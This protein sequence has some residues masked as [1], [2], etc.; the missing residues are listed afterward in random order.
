MAKQIIWSSEQQ[1]IFNYFK[2]GSG[3][4]CIEALAGCGKTSTIEEGI[5]HA[6]EKR[7]LYAVFGKRNQL[8]AMEKIIDPR[9][10]IATIHSVGF[11]YLKTVWP[12]CH[13]RFSWQVECDR[14]KTACPEF[15]EEFNFIVQKLISLLKNLYINPTLENAKD[16]AGIRGLEIYGEQKKWNDEI[17]RIAI[18]AIELSKRPDKSNR[19]SFDDMVYLPA[20]LQL[21]KPQYDMVVLDEGQDLNAPQFD[22]ALGSCKS[23]GRVCLVADKNQNIFGFRGTLQ[24]G[25]EIFKQKLKA[26]SFPLT[27]TFRCPRSVVQQAQRLVPSYQSHESAPEGEVIKMDYKKVI[28]VIKPGDVLLSRKNSP[29]TPM[30]LKLLRKKISCYVVGRD[31]GK[32]LISIIKGLEAT[33]TFDFG[34]KLQAWHDVRTGLVTG[35]SVT[36]KIELIKD[37]YETLKE[38]SNW[39]ISEGKNSIQDIIDTINGLFYDTEFVKRPSVICSSIHRGKGLEWAT[40]YLLC[41]T[42]YVSHPKQTQDEK[43]AEKCLEYVGITRSKNKLVLVSGLGKD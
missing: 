3:N 12:R 5:R 41:D 10:T 42:L 23:T 17:P 13:A 9:V 43:D 39:V 31:I 40:V 18:E 35:K 32:Q 30:A 8:E 4:A 38:I 37:Q 6:P 16:I 22:I 11:S 21:V 34:N 20:A 26:E 29:L 25:I 27:I 15:P 2:S 28:E 36:S 7:I 33:D 24:N 19:I 1:N 14:I